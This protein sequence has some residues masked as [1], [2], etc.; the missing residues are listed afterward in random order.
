MALMLH[1]AADA[2]AAAGV[3]LRWRS[4]EMNA[5]MVNESRKTA[6]GAKATKNQLQPSLNSHR[7]APPKIYQASNEQPT[8]LTLLYES[9]CLL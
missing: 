1:A 9:T 2:A 7:F 4:M 8:Y 6:I 5:K 3:Y